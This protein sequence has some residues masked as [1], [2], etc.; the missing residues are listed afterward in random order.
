VRTG[1]YGQRREAALA[2]ATLRRRENAA[3]VM[4]PTL[5]DR[6]GRPAEIALGELSV[7]SSSSVPPVLPEPPEAPEVLPAAATAVATAAAKSVA[8][9]P[10]PRDG[11]AY[12]VQLGAFSSMENA[13]VSLAFWQRKGYE[14]FVADIRDVGGRPWYAVRSGVYPQRSD[15][16]LSALF[17]GRGEDTPAVVVKTAV[18]Q[19]GAAKTV[20]VSRFVPTASVGEARS[21]APVEETP[22]KRATAP[23]SGFIANAVFKGR[24]AYAVQ[25]G[26]FASLENAAKFVADWEGRGYEAY[27]CE[28]RDSAQKI[29]YAVRAGAFAQRRKAASLAQ[30][31]TRQ[32]NER[33][34]VVPALLDRSG[35]LAVVD[36]AAFEQSSGG[37]N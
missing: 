10:S 5:V 14:V 30:T 22:P 18:D 17:F 24:K 26:A 33:A 2:A 6:S 1:V 32:E 19:S 21:A 11:F 37:E 25:L 9:Q 29:R 3:A 28:T 31:I 4:V 7:P 8:P 23:R 13:A 16:A 12:S 35:R 20:D 34:V 27:V 15:A 36:I